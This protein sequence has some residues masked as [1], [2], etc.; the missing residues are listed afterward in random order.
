MSRRTR[1]YRAMGRGGPRNA[2]DAERLA[3]EDL[4]GLCV[5]AL[6][7]LRCAETR[8]R[9]K[10]RTEYDQRNL[11]EV[12]RAKRDVEDLRSGLA[13]FHPDRLEK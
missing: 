11:V 4:L 1:S 6:D 8:I 13:D 5:S 2:F 12:L 10:A 9:C 3:L 7:S